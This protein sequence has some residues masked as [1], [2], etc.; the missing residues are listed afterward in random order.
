MTAHNW[1]M[2][3][4][5]YE[6]VQ[7]ALCGVFRLTLHSDKLGTVTRYSPPHAD[8]NNTL[9][10]RTDQPPCKQPRTI[11]TEDTAR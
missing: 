9:R 10:W 1:V 3:S 11:Y 5:T 8:I 7:C 4:D 2:V 6:T